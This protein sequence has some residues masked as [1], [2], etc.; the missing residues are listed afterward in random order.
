VSTL[1]NPCIQ[2]PAVSIETCTAVPVNH[3]LSKPSHMYLYMCNA[4]EAPSCNATEAH[5]F[6]ECPYIVMCVHS[7]PSCNATEA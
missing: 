7:K 1:A 3:S 4:T 6:V 2:D 5:V